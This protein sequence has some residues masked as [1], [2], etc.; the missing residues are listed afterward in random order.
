MV[1]GL[2]DPIK[3]QKLINGI[4]LMKILLASSTILTTKPRV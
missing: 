3:F 1:I 2:Y 4:K